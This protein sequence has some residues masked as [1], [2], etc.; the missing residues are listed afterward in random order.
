MSAVAVEGAAPCTIGADLQYFLDVLNRRDPA[1][2][3]KRLMFG[4]CISISTSLIG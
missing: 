1:V 4:R 3:L 2:R